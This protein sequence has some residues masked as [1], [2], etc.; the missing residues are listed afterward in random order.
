MSVWFR[1]ARVKDATSTAPRGF[2]CSDVDLFHLHHRIERSLCGSG[3]GIGDRFRQDDRRNLPGQSPF[4]LAPA[5][6]A[7]LAAVADNRVPI[8]IRFGLVSGCDLK[9]ERLVVLERRSSVE[10][11]ARK[12]HHGKLDGQH[13]PFLSRRKVSWCAVHRSDRRIRKGL[14]VEPRRVLGVIFV[15]KANSVLCWLSHVAS[16][17][18]S[19]WSLF[20]WDQVANESSNLA[21]SHFEHVTESEI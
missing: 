6:L 1:D 2:D 15:P 10:P 9:R 21:V 14:G 4:V 19:A 12:P 8:A 16:P 20:S 5:A 7:L 3:I 17:Y 11:E 18:E 13:I